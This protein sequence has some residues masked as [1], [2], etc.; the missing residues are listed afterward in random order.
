MFN[1]GGVVDRA[2]AGDVLSFQMLVERYQTPILR[3]LYRLVGDSELA[4]E[5]TLETFVSANKQLRRVDANLRFEAWL[6][7]LATRRA[8]AAL[9]ARRFTAWLPRRAA[10]LLSVEDDRDGQIVQQ[11]LLRVP[12]GAA[13]AL[14]LW[15]MGGFSYAE[16]ARILHI[17]ERSVGDRV[18][19]ARRRLCDLGAAGPA[20]AASV[21]RDA[22]QPLLSPYM[23][24]QLAGEDH[25]AV[26]QH[27]ATCASCK[28]VLASYQELDRRL[29]RMKSRGP[30]AAVA[31]DVTRLLRGE[32]LPAAKHRAGRRSVLLLGLGLVAVVVLGTGSIA[33]VRFARSL[34]PATS[35]GVLFV[36][37]LNAEGQVA[38]VDVRTARLVS[39]LSVG[40]RP[41]KL[42]AGR[43]GRRVFVLSDNSMISVI[44][45]AQRVVSHRYEVIGRAA[46]MALSPD[47]KMLYVTLSDRRSLIY[48]DTESGRQNAEV[49]VGRSPREVI[50]SPDGQWLIVFNASDNSVSKVRVSTRQEARVLPLLRRGD[51][52][53]EFS[54][55]PMAFSPDGRKAYVAELNRERMWSI[56]MAT[57]AATSTDV[58][59]RDLGRDIVVAPSGD[60]LYV[61]HGD[62]R[63]QRAALAGLA[64]MTLPKAERTAEIRGSYYGV[65]L[66][67]DGTTVFATNPD[68]NVVI[69]ADAQTLQTKETIA[70][71]QSPS[72]IVWV[73]AP[74]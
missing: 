74:Q 43:D 27:L 54:L 44:D 3:Y 1:S 8:Q 38:V 62:P 58:P 63:G 65:A 50:A 66:S 29:A 49:R 46:G 41:I 2:R 21:R 25:A 14:L 48:V 67:P 17:S 19:Q 45:V 55:H 22:V 36:G 69:F 71:G 6:H 5:L 52:P 37:L 4:R 15:N 68:D 60:Q 24:H 31:Y 16:I 59:L 9:R 30:S 10:P 34:P 47:D 26:E 57:D 53:V 28:S 33:A 23:D 39:T 18:S 72:G 12:T 64:I 61:T 35:A 40:G 56:D 70:V 51:S 42:V 20:D 73:A 13:V 32:K 7:R 11:A